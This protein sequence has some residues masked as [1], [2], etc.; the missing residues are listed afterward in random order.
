LGVPQRRSLSIEAHHGESTAFNLMFY[1]VDSPP[2]LAANTQTNLFGFN[3]L[4][5]STVLTPLIGTN[6]YTLMYE[7]KFI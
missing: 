2:L 3:D 7:H 5:N 4:S 1:S 6:G